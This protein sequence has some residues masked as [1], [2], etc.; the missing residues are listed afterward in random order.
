MRSLDGEAR[1]RGVTLPAN[2]ISIDNVLQFNKIYAFIT[3]TVLRRIDFNAR[4]VVTFEFERSERHPVHTRR[5]G[6]ASN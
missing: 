2:Y 1:N 3:R 6:F 4:T 5:G